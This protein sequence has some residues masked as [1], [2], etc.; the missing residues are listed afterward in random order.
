MSLGQALKDYPIT[1]QRS[2]VPEGYNKIKG[3]NQRCYFKLETSD[4]SNSLFH[5]KTISDQIMKK[6]QQS[7]VM[8]FHRVHHKFRGCLLLITGFHFQRFQIHSLLDKIEWLFHTN[9]TNF[10]GISWQQE[11]RFHPQ[12]IKPSLIFQEYYG[13]K[14]YGSA[15]SV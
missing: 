8:H 15:R 7:L 6:K 12:S 1:D 13:N 11:L 9:F 10:S 14:I 4:D 2:R 3:E 5:L